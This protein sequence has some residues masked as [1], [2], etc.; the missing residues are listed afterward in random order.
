MIFKSLNPATGEPFK[1]WEH[2]TDAQVDNVLSRAQTSYESW[3]KQPYQVKS[4]FLVSFAGQLR[5]N[6]KELARLA[7]QEMGKPIKQALGEV[8]KSAALCEYYAKHGQDYLK[9]L[10][11]DMPNGSGQVYYQPLGPIFCIMPWNYPYWQVLRCVVPSLLLG[12]TVIL[13][14]APNV[15]GCASALQDIFEKMDGTPGLF[16]HVI[17]DND[18]AANIIRDDRVFG[19]ALTGSERAGSAVAAIAGG[20]LKKC[21]LELGGSDPFIVLADANM[22]AAIEGVVASRY[23]NAG[24]VCIA[25]KRIFVDAAIEAEFT[26][27]LVAKT[28]TLSVGDPELETTDMG[29]M[30]RDDL[31]AELHAQVLASIDLGAKLLT[32]GKMM[33]GDGYYYAPTILTNI[34]PDA[35][36]LCQETFG[37]VAALCSFNGLEEAISL[38]NKTPYG[39][40]ASIWTQDMSTARQLSR[41]LECGN[42][43]INSM[44]FSDPRLPFGG[45]KKSGFGRELSSFGLHEFANVKSVYSHGKGL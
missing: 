27:R 29:P 18:Q 3:S 14:H 4:E 19:V 20:A 1:T 31:R 30:A 37:P 35:P 43:F 22:D 10:S 25:A 9:G 17:A 38:S 6:A 15:L 12:N 16:Q 28:K 7:T 24:Q 39:L 2:H 13:K 32:G 23:G 42:V 36:V 40:S 11:V 26:E 41:A 8:E 5:Q 33:S 21:V 34:P 44:S 45:V